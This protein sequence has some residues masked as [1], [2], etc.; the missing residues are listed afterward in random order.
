MYC[1]FEILYKDV[2]MQRWQGG[3]RAVIRTRCRF[4]PQVVIRCLGV[5][6][7]SHLQNHKNGKEITKVFMYCRFEFIRTR[8]RFIPQVVVRCLGV[9]INSHLQ[10]HK[11]LCITMI[12]IFLFFSNN[13]N[14][15]RFLIFNFSR[16]IIFTGTFQLIVI[17]I[18]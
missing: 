8:C 6:I 4:I 3:H 18:I 10:N 15:P 5:R 1:R 12:K 7:N 16:F 11:N 2:L 17:F 13:I 14:H 9:R